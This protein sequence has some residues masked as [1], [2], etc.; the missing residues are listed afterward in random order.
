MKVSL[1]KIAQ[2]LLVALCGVAP[3]QAVAA[4][5]P[6]LPGM[7]NVSAYPITPEEADRIMRRQTTSKSVSTA[8]TSD[9]SVMSMDSASLSA[10]TAPASITE[11]AR[12][13]K[14]DPDLIYEYVRNNIEFYPIWGV[15]KGPV[16]TILD[17]AGT[18]FD[19]ASLMV[20]LLRQAGYTASYVI[21][22]IHLTG[23]QLSD[24]MGVDT[25]DACAT[26]NV[27]GSGQLQVKGIAPLVTCPS[28]TPTTLTNIKMRHVWVKA[29]IGGTA[30]YFDP[31]YKPYTTKTGID[32]VTASGYSA[33]TYLSSAKTNATITS[34]YVQSI[35]STNI[36]N[37]LTTY[38]TNLANYL[39]TNKP[40]AVLEDVVGGRVITPHGGANL[41]QTVL[42]YQDTTVALTE[43]SDIPDNYRPTLRIR[44]LGI[45]QTYTSDAIYG[46]R[47]TITYNASNQPVLML[48]GVSQQTGSATTLGSTGTVTLN[49]DHPA[50]VNPLGYAS[51]ESTQ[52]IKA[53]QG[54]TYLISNSWGTMGRG[55]IE[56]H[57]AVLDEARASAAADGSEVAL[58]SALAVVS[59]TFMSQRQRLI[60]MVNSMA[61]MIRINHHNVGIVG[62][63][64]STYVDLPGNVHSSIAKN[65]QSKKLGAEFSNS[66][67]SSIF[68]ST[69][70]QQATGVS[71]VSTTKLIDI[72]NSN[73]D[74][75]YDAKSSNY[76]STVR[77][78]LTACSALL[79]GFESAVNAGRRLILPA[80]C[81]ITEASWQGAGYYS[82]LVEN[83][84]QKAFGALISGGLLGGFA[85]SPQPVTQTVPKALDFS[86][87]PN[88]L[89]QNS[90][91]HF[92]DPIDMVKGHY[93]YS[94]NDMT[95][96]VGEFPMSLNFE[97]LYSSG[98]RTQGKAGPMGL[99][100]THNLVA[101][102]AMGTDGFQGLGEDSALDAVNSIVEAMVSIDLHNDAA[103]PLDKIV[104]STVGQRWFGDQLVDNTVIVRQGLNGEVY[105]KLPD[106][107]YNAPPGNSAKLIKN[108]NNTYTLE[109]VNK[110]K[111]DF[112]TTG[113]I[114][115]Y[116]HTNGVQVKYAY[117]GND[118]TS[119]TNS[120]GRSLTFTNTSGRITRVAD[121]TRNVNYAYDTATGNL[122]S[123]T[124]AT[125]K[126]TTFQ[127]D[128]PGRMTKLFYPSFPTVAFL[129]NVYDS[130]GRVQTQTNANNNL[131][132]Y[133]FAGS[134]SEEVGPGNVSRVSFLDGSGKVIK[135]IN[136]LGQI[137]TN[138]YD[139][140]TRLVKKTLP[141]GNSIEYVYDDAPCSAQ[142]RC[143][144]NVKT[145][146]QVPKPNSGLATLTTNMTYES[147]FNRLAT[148][149][150]PRQHLS[151][152][153]TYTA[154]GLPLTVT[155]ATDDS[156]VAPK[157]TYGYLS[158]TPIGFSTFYLPNNET[159]N[160]SSTASLTN[161]VTYN[162]TNRYVPATKVV[163][164]GTGKLNL[165]TSYTY[166]AFGNLTQENGPRTDV[167]DITNYSYDA[168]RRVTKLTNAMDKITHKGYDA[169][170]RGVRSAAQI[171]SQ[172][173]VSCKTYTNTGK[174]LK[175]WGPSTTALDTSC[176]TA[177]A[178]VPVTDY[179]YD[180]LDRLQRVTEN[181]TTAEGGNRVTE[182][183][184][185]A[186]DSVA[187]VKKA[188]GTSVAQ[189]YVINTYTANGLLATVKDAK[190]NLTTYEYDGHDRKFK[191]RFPN[192]LTTNTSSTTDFKQ[193]SYDSNGNV[194]EL[195]KRSGGIEGFT[196]DKLNRKTSHVLTPS[197][198]T[199][200]PKSIVYSYDL[201]GRKVLSQEVAID[202]ASLGDYYNAASYVWDNAGRLIQANNIVV[203][204]SYAQLIT[205]T[206]DEAG[207]LTR[208]NYP[209]NGGFYITRSYDLLN[210]LTDIKEKGSVSLAS[211][212]YDDL[213]R[214]TGVT[215]GNGT[216]TSYSYNA[217][218]SL[219]VLS[220]DLV[221]T[222]QDIAWNYGRNQLGEINSNNWNIND[223]QWIEGSNRTVTYTSANGLNQYPA[224]SGLSLL[225]DT[226][227]N[228]YTDGVWT[229]SY[230][231]I[232]QLRTAT[233]STTGFAGHLSYD[234]EK[235]LSRTKLP[236]S[237]IPNYF[238]YDGSELIVE[239]DNTTL[240]RRYVYGPGVD[241]PIV[242]YEGSGTTYKTWLY[243][244][245]QGSIVA[246]ADSAGTMTAAYTYGPFGEPNVTTGS[247]FRYTGQQYLGPLNLYYYKA[248]FYSPTLGR[249]LQTDPIGY[250]DDMNLYA[251]VGNNP[252]NRTDPSGMWCV[253]CVGAA[254][255]GVLG[256]SSSV[257]GSLAVGEKGI[258]ATLEDPGTW[259]A[260]AVSGA[261]GAWAG[262][263]G[264]VS[265][266]LRVSMARGAAING[267]SNF[268]GQTVTL[269]SDNN[270]S[271]NL[272]YNLG[273][274]S[275]SAVGGAW[276]GALTRS[277]GP[278]VSAVLGQMPATSVEALGGAIYNHSS[279]NNSSNKLNYSSFK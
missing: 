262:S 266:G 141:E 116:T 134:R 215:W 272:D 231:S 145:V 33:A 85:S 146:G 191:T 95:T 224:V 19:Q 73:G 252:I 247:R 271:N 44:Y 223:Y 30:Y 99:G 47:L 172:W 217:Q 74:R 126:A 213:S 102:V 108:A 113:K 246:T 21:G 259:A 58:G 279:L 179:A 133:Y 142:K 229:Y 11:L 65:S 98:N 270:S 48:D 8:P 112:D 226:E 148:V 171:G 166:D 157:T 243:A 228:L 87:S 176:P 225:Y 107:T 13:L 238:I 222:A 7:N 161:S 260:A 22:T 100:W 230:N 207:N 37:N 184:Y 239:Y 122:I 153:H 101:N 196:Y 123:F 160:I 2:V 118:L 136:P 220:L 25:S 149:I 189:S 104:I 6:L 20:S 167:S 155:G 54:Y 159:K 40:A 16:G 263:Y 124:D 253:P 69:A 75:I 82:I 202:G 67:H 249:F 38:S 42:P 163:D 46:K 265:A 227:A 18:A 137:T 268:A 173:M 5:T 96:G 130:L 127:Y 128:L 278:V 90:F 180:S 52:P 233:N 43:M 55:Y 174:E 86:I 168:E 276:A 199:S 234:S 235:R 70:V 201:L 76:A 50:Y 45:D 12:A 211:Y 251:Y 164:S 221:G 218:N 77:P 91:T 269:N 232:G 59:G 197:A 175:A 83:G 1:N 198:L 277:T 214:R 143:T 117:S 24:W 26:L 264:D 255:G 241:E 129:T 110:A 60:E 182:L 203:N 28:A 219:G 51:Q 61:G 36:R 103:M 156:G 64:G 258:I 204:S 144:H 29:M 169:D 240:A 94:R 106:G 261:A 190:N 185:N 250:A 181:M 114:A 147:S 78:N 139:G 9:T 212:V 245:H 49:I 244:D 256:A 92:G 210:R 131:Y 32:L 150:N 111:M 62:Y 89:T 132:S 165:T 195:R 237:A 14:N 79:T 208:T 206:Y 27:M 71:G 154:Q 68:E 109:T 39:R 23:P 178:P 200:E 66:V 81:D 158:V 120:L 53:G 10:P 216:F 267:A 125:L 138:T 88:V 41:R 177:A 15:H 63:S 188:V 274:L 97:R 273:A 170:G 236:N 183:V 17:N 248:R 209:G 140:Q 35:N 242:K 121:G 186:D 3:L 80:R 257:L 34:D 151:A 4:V 105:V 72:A 193:Y 135:E 187:S 119:V 254:V 194:I 31:S 152:T 192:K 162:T 205:Y 93:L 57:R 115:T 84:E 56:K 275:G